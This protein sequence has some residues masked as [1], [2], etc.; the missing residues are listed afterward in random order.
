[1]TDMLTALQKLWPRGDQHVPGLIEGIAAAAPTVFPKYFPTSTELVTA[2]FMAQCSEECAAGLE[3]SENMNYTA[4]RLLQVFPSHFTPSLAARAA[5][6]PQMIAE[7]A[8][9][10][11]MGN[12][13]P[14]STDGWIY[15]GQGLT[16]CTGHDGF[17][18]LQAWLDKEGIALD[19][20][21]NPQLICAPEHALLCG[22]G[23][24]I[25]CGCLPYA[26]KNEV[27]NVSAM[28]NVGHIVP[29]SRINGLADREHWT[30]LWKRELGI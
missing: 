21:S 27:V 30:A 17:A 24:F 25:L 16:N 11:R 20:M 29:A 4:Q 7:I 28:L 23:D 12:K 3:M 14:P 1:M 10:G 2:I 5:H 26:E 19:L 13:P 8:Y 15:R 6:N 18:A 9:G 22:V